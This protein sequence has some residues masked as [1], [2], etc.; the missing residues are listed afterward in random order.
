MVSFEIEQ[1]A[2][3]AGMLQRDFD[4]IAMSRSP[5]VLENLVV[6]SHEHPT[7][8]WQHCVLELRVK[9]GVIRRAAIQREILLRDITALGDSLE[10]DLKRI[11][12]EDLEFAALGAVREFMALYQIY[13]EFPHFTREQ[14]DAGQAD[15]WRERLLKQARQDILA[16]S[17]IGA[18]NIDALRQIGWN[19]AIENGQI[20]CEQLQRT[21]RDPQRIT[22]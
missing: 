14:L 18:G 15:Y 20:I 2:E 7:V 1:I 5:Y 10:A 11:D 4:T 22:D 6:K 8:Q 12:L 19:V 3:I 13:Q 17:R 21:D 9:W 16:T